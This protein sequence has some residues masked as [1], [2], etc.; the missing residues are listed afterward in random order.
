MTPNDKGQYI[1]EDGH[2]I[3]QMW[4]VGRRF[5]T[6]AYYDK[7]RAE[8]TAPGGTSQLGFLHKDAV[9]HDNISDRPRYRAFFDLGNDNLIELQDPMTDKEF[10]DYTPWHMLAADDPRLVTYAASLPLAKL[11][12]EKRKSATPSKPAARKRAR[13]G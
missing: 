10:Q 1:T 13:V 6:R 8:G 12:P 4:S 2:Y 9:G 11:F 5:P 3:L 7:M